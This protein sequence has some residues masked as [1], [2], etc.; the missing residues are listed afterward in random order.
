MVLGG[1]MGGGGS[2]DGPIFLD[3]GGLML[4]NCGGRE[5]VG[6]EKDLERGKH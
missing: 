2:Y 1:Y 6:R 3:P 4:Y 5:G